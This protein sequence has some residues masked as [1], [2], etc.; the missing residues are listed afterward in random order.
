MA[1]HLYLNRNITKPVNSHIRQPEISSAVGVAWKPRVL[2]ERKKTTKRS[3]T[4]SPS[5]E[6]VLALAPN[7]AAAKNSATTPTATPPAMSA[8]API[9]SYVLLLLLLPLPSPLHHSSAGSKKEDQLLYV[10]QKR[11]SF[12]VPLFLYACRRCFSLRAL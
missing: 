5:F 1:Q 8:A 2:W 11:A 12:V 10:R 3:R 4:H 6:S 7:E 9:P